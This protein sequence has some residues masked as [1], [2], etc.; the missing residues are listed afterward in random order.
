MPDGGRGATRTL[1]VEQEVE[2]PPYRFFERRAGSGTPVVLIHGLGG[3]SDWWL[4][5]FDAIAREHLVSA[6]D[7]VGFGRTR[8]FLKKSSLPPSF[9]ETAAMLARWIESSFTEP[10]HL[11]GN[12]MGG[13]IAIHV[14]A[15]RP[16]LVRS[17]TLIN[18]TG[19]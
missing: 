8:F 9:L 4:R 14:A 5:N 17:L 13:H 12:S 7:L 11:V 3:S 16:D 15:L 1:G 18:S 2:L 10:V 19:I 6:V